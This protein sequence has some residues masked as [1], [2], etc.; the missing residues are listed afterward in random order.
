MNTDFIKEE[1][2]M[3]TTKLGPGPMAQWRLNG[4]GLLRILFGIVWGIDAWFKWQPDFVNNFTTYLTGAQ[5]G[6]PWPIHHW[7]GF[8]STPSA[9]TQR[10]SLLWLP[11]VRRRLQ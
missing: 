6:Q 11:W 3:E 2:E 1:I 9:S 4:I 7:I 10:L 8:W 5:D